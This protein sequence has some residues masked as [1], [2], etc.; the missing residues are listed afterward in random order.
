MREVQAG[1]RLDIFGTGD[2]DL[3]F[4]VILFL[5]REQFG[6]QCLVIAGFILSDTLLIEKN[7]VFTIPVIFFI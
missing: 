5:K 6:R 3:L 7:R 2:G 1:F 4:M